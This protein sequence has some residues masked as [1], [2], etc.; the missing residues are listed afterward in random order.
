MWSPP[1][2]TVEHYRRIL[3]ERRSGLYMD[4]PYQ[5][6]FESLALCNAKCSFCPYPGL[7][8]K[9]AVMADAL[10]GKILDDCR[11]IPEELPFNI[12]PY[13]VSEPFLDTRVF[14]I[15]KQ[16]N[17]TLPNAWIQIFSN[18]SPLNS[19]NLSKLAAVRNMFRLVISLHE[20][21]PQS[22][23]R[24]VGIPY[25]RTIRNV[26]ALHAMK[27]S[28][29]ISFPVEISRVGDGSARDREFC[30]W[31]RNKFPLFTVYATARTNWI[32]AVSTIV[33]PIPQ[34]PCGQ[35]FNLNFLPSGREMFCC[36]DANGR[37][38]A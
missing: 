3:D 31:G 23:E 18:G 25:E 11:S 27:E 36:V 7:D 1:Q 30:E 38:G 8:R 22:Y 6:S 4:Y 20:M 37:W 35:W 28:G 16:I 29:G 26:E 15:C 33:S 13:Q 32:G 21:D 19:K 24:V 9:G 5:V 17:D 14:D 10:I 2:E 34:A 12:N